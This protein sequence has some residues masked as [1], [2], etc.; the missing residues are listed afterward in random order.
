MS[1]QPMCT[2]LLSNYFFWCVFVARHEEHEISTKWSG[3]PVTPHPAVSFKPGLLSIAVVRLFSEHHIS[4]APIQVSFHLKGILKFPCLHNANTMIFYPG[5]WGWRGDWGHTRNLDVNWTSSIHARARHPSE[6][7]PSIFRPVNLDSITAIVQN[8]ETGLRVGPFESGSRS[9]ED[10][11]VLCCFLISFRILFSGGCMGSKISLWLPQNPLIAVIPHEWRFGITSRSPQ[12]SA[13]FCLREYL[14]RETRNRDFANRYFTWFE[15]RAMEIIENDEN[16]RWISRMADN[17]GIFQT[18]I[19]SS[20]VNKSFETFDQTA[21][22]CAVN[23]LVV[24]LCV[25]HHF[26]PNIDRPLRRDQLL[27]RLQYGA[28]K[29]LMLS[30]GE[31]ISWESDYNVINSPSLRFFCFSGHWKPQVPFSHSR[32]IGRTSLCWT[33]SGCPDNLRV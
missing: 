28:F 33:C 27:R 18:S 15:T 31:T 30:I 11:Q 23:S 6:S 13:T 4:G 24:S 32:K 9:R 8:C 25:R 20:A 16:K 17:F 3:Y 29:V 7:M 22:F 10:D 26:E 12:E 21:W 5:P 2:L 1:L 14:S 19:S